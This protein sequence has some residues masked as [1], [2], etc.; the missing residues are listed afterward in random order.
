MAREI[1]TSV[2]CE[3][4]IRWRAAKDELPAMNEFVLIWR[5]GGKNNHNDVGIGYRAHQYGTRDEW[6]WRDT[7]YGQDYW[8]I[9]IDG[10]EVI[11]WAYKPVMERP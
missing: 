10:S 2:R 7:G 9:S 3:T 4:V 8:G 6:E 1:E 11:A 5:V